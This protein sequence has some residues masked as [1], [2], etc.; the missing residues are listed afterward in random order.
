MQKNLIA[1]SKFVASVLVLAIITLTANAQKQPQVQEVSVRAPANIKIDGKLNEWANPLLNAFNST[2]RIYYVVS[3]DDNNLYL[4]VRGLGNGVAKKMLAG[5]MTF[6]ISKATDK[7]RTKATDNVAVTFPV[8]Q[9]PQTTAVIMGTINAILNFSD[10]TVANRKQID[11]VT[12]MAN[13]LLKNAIREIQ[14]VG[15]KE[16]PDSVLS[17]YNTEGIKAAVQFMQIQPIVEL[18]IPLK[19]LGLSIDNPIKFSYNIKLSEIPVQSMSVDITK[20]SAVNM[21]PNN[22]FA[23]NPTDFWGEYILAK[24]P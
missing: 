20:V 2:D 7:K 17:I 19:Y 1:Q 4:T 23:F 5:G 24:K 21:S 16:I 14:V 22:G 3:N 10:D 13:R 6:T 8:P 15:I 18:A 11:S 9:E 12:V